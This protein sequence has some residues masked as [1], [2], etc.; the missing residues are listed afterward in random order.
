MIVYWDDPLLRFPDRL[1]LYA[2]GGDHAGPPAP[3]NERLRLWLKDC[4]VPTIDQTLAFSRHL[5]GSRSW[6]K[7]LP[8]FP[9]GARFAFLLNPNAGMKVERVGDHRIYRPDPGAREGRASFGAWTCEVDLDGVPGGLEKPE[10]PPHPEGEGSPGMSLYGLP[11]ACFARFTAFLRPTPALVAVCLRRLGR[12]IP[13]YDR[14]ARENPDHPD[15]ARHETLRRMAK[16][17]LENPASAWKSLS[18]FAQVEGAHQE[19]QLSNALLAA[20]EAWIRFLGD[21]PA[22]GATPA[23]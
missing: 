13:I 4:P 23:G 8:L 2:R 12:E 10:D 3:D 15:V 16:E 7:H 14:W 18:G 6:Y 11:A 17:I 19:Q 1:K 21:A 5:P 9:P 22:T 20:R